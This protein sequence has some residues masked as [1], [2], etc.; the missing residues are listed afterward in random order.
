MKKL[1]FLFLAV[2]LSATALASPTG[3]KMGEQRDVLIMSKKQSVNQGRPRAPELTLFNACLDT[4]LCAL[5]ISSAY[6]VNEVTACVE[7]LSTG[8][9]SVYSFDSSETAM[10]PISCTAGEWQLTLT[11]ES[12]A[13]YV[14]EFQI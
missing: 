9:Y 11:L 2:A 3:N 12:G 14:G 7:N 6:D 10:L 8:V 5:F 13:E 4:D 1:Y